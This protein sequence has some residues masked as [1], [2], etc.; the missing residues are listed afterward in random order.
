MESFLNS[1]TPHLSSAI[2]MA[3]MKH[4][5]TGDRM[6]DSTLQM[7]FSTLTAAL[8]SGLV[9][10][11]TK[12]Y[13]ID[14]CNYTLSLWDSKH[15]NPLK[16]DPRLAP[17][18]PLNGTCYLYRANWDIHNPEVFLSWFILNHSDK[19]Y[20]Q[21]MEKSFRLLDNNVDRVY[22][23]QGGIDTSYMDGRQLNTAG[24][25][26]ATI[27]EKTLLPIW[28][29]KSGDFVF[30][31]THGRMAYE[32][33]IALY[34]DSR[35]ALQNC[36]AHILQH[37]K[38][39]DSYKE[40]KIAKYQTP[41][42]SRIYNTDSEGVGHHA[43]EVIN[44]NKVFESLFF[45]QK[46]EVVDLLA[47]FKEGTLF[48][49]HIPVD[50]KLGFILYG[51]P[52]TGKTGLISAMANYLQR[53]VV[54]VDTTRVK[55]RKAFDKLLS[56][57]QKSF[58][59]VFEEF[60]CMPGVCRRDLTALPQ[61]P[62]EQGGALPPHAY[63]MMLMSEK[64]TSHKEMMDEYRKEAAAKADTLDLGYILRK[65]DGL[66]SADG[67]IIVA[68]TNHPERIDPA[69]L[70]PGRFGHRIHLTRCTL[71]MLADIISMVYHTDREA[72]A[73]AVATI[74][75]QKWSPAEVLQLAISMSQEALLKH[76]H[77]QEPQRD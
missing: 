18:D 54:I 8:L 75:D 43:S 44:Q 48:P 7:L 31:T 76:L 14:L 11:Y 73:A 50:N 46:D 22:Q 77:E 9:A 68:T 24:M 5:N 6:L 65:L 35:F 16:F 56:L 72:I 1:V 3:T 47:K 40:Q 26:T 34:S 37:S 71:T 74:P 12:G 32:D 51:P 27:P 20:T 38:A 15:Y 28:R 52:G 57:N 63:A 67:R 19:Q 69:L 58:I 36:L 23:N 2:N 29:E 17:K 66:E 39:M 30:A 25:R 59:Y 33:G 70:R 64:D 13:W 53:D 41:N 4:V 61:Q 55:T 60:D 10:L 21:K 42:T 49:K 62:Q 45:T